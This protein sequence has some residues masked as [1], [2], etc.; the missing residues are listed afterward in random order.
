[1]GGGRGISGCQD[2]EVAVSVQVDG[3]RMPE[4]GRSGREVAGGDLPER[5]ILLVAEDT[6]GVKGAPCSGGGR[7]DEIEESVV[8]HVRPGDSAPGAACGDDV[9]GLLGCLAFERPVSAISREVDRLC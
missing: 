9:A 4:A 1:M 2:V 8:V 3:R 5:P 6:G 7:G